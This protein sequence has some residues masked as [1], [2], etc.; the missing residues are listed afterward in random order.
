[1]VS[2]LPGR[3]NVQ[4]T[5]KAFEQDIATINERAKFTGLSAAEVIHEMCDELRKQNYLNEL[6]ESLDALTAN[7]KQLAELQAEQELW[8]C[9]LADGLPDAF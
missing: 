8:D 5:V 3:H 6:G 9:A 2:A 7:T 4:K 1:M